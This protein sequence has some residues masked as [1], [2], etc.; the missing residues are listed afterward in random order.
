MRE[1]RW[2]DK[3]KEG[4]KHIDSNDRL[5]NQD[6]SNTHFHPFSVTCFAILFLSAHFPFTWFLSF[7]AYIKQET[8]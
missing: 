7:K 8:Q 6:P 1:E 2:A 4:A 5:T 3:Q